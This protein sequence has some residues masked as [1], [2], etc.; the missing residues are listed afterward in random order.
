L[1]IVI[2]YNFFR[3]IHSEFKLPLNLDAIYEFASNQIHRLFPIDVSSEI[4]AM[5]VDQD[6]DATFFEYSEAM[7]SKKLSLH[8]KAQLKWKKQEDKKKVKSAQKKPDFVIDLCKTY[9]KCGDIPPLLKKLFN[10]L[11]SIPPTSVESER[12]FSITGQF[13]TKLRTKL[14]DNT[15]NSLVFLKASYK[16]ESKS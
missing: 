7:D 6:G 16:K 4:E 12:A 9:A 11:K 13:A 2:W 3:K 14:A 10:A 5:E 8:E 15:L 1:R